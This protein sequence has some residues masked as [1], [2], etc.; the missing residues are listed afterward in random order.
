MLNVPGQGRI[1]HLNLQHEQ[2]TYFIVSSFG[3]L[4]DGRVTFTISNVREAQ[5]QL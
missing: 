2:R 3:L 5:L 1:H 4:K